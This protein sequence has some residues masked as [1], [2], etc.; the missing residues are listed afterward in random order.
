MASIPKTDVAQAIAAL[1]RTEWGR[2]VAILIRLVGDFD[3]A[4]EA[5]QA[6]FT[7]AVNQWESDGIPDRPRAWI[8]RTARYKAIDHLRR[9]TKLTEKLEWY[10]ASGLIPSTE[11]PTYDSDEIADD[12]LRLIFTCCHPALATETQVALTLRMLGGLETDEIARAFLI[13]TATMAQRLVRAKRK[14]RDAGI[15]YKVP[16]TTDL[17]PRIEVV[18]R[19]IYLIFNEG[20]A[21]TKGD[22]I[23]RADLCIEAIRLGQLVR[24][25]LAPQPPSEVTALVALML[26]HDSRRNARLDEAGDLILLEDQDRSRWNHLQIAEALPLVE[27]ALLFGTGVYAL[28]AAIA[29]LHC[30]ATRAEETDW[31]QIVR[32]YEVLEG[33]QPSPIV[34][35]NRAVAIA[36]ADSPQAAFALIDSLAPELDSYHLFHATRADLFRRVGALEKA[37]QS[38]TRALELVTNDSERRFLERRLREVQPNIQSG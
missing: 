28:Q 26:L 37:T 30:Q 10:A 17:A 25:L 23:V 2:I 6:A 20:Y 27:E 12:R 11:E 1:Y 8:I 32:L 7:A 4:E 36:M 16:E 34:T 35:L 13:P 3:V 5:A 31:V 38:Y 18:L 29:A 24:Q 15:P 9:R 33:L 14:I 21:A 19:V 22:A